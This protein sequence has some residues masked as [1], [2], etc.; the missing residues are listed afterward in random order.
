[1]QTN[2]ADV[3][4]RP[5]LSQPLPSGNILLSCPTSRYLLSLVGL[6]LHYYYLVII[7][8]LLF[9]YYFLAISSVASCCSRFSG[10]SAICCHM[11]SISPVSW[12]IFVFCAQHFFFLPCVQCQQRRD[13]QRHEWRST[14][15][16]EQRMPQLHAPL[17]NAA[18]TR[19]A[20]FLSPQPTPSG[21]PF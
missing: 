12:V 14:G 7:Y 1:M 9:S 3:I 18:V 21:D 6:L 4:D 11:W 13:N 5:V 20:F 15:S 17:T 19:D 10:L 2:L 8:L 16:A